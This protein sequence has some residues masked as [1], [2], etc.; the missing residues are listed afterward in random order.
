M[1]SEAFAAIIAAAHRLAG[2]TAAEFDY[3]MAYRRTERA[4]MALGSAIYDAANAGHPEVTPGAIDIARDRQ[5]RAEELQ[6][7]LQPQIEAFIARA[8][9][10]SYT[11][12]SGAS[13]GPIRYA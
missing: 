6:A 12:W 3:D 7:E 4:R 9:A 5:R 1:T 13:Q 10:Q 8:K 11:G 2:M